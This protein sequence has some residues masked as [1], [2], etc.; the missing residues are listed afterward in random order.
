[1]KKQWDVRTSHC[2]YLIAIS[3]ISLQEFFLA[4]SLAL[5]FIS[6]ILS[7]E[8]NNSSKTSFALSF[9]LIQ[10]ATPFS[11]KNVAFSSS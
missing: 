3:Q 8:L 7:G 11:S 2:F 9:F 1:M 4:R 10:I 6:F 5:T